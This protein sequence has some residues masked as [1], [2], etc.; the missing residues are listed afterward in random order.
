MSFSFYKQLNE[1]D[2]GPTCLRMVAKYYGRHYNADTIRQKTGFS[3]QGVSLLGI[4]ET[5][6]KLGFKTRG[7]Q[8]TYDKLLTIA[9]P[10][11]LH[12]NQNHF[13]V[14]VSMNKRKVQIADPARGMIQY[15]TKEFLP[16][17]LSNKK[18]GEEQAGTV[19]LLEPA[20]SFYEEEGEKENKLNWNIITR[21]LRPSKWSI[22][23]VFVAL[24]IGSL[25]QLILP[26]LSQ[27]M[28]DTGINTRNMQY[29]TI[30][31]VAQL[32]LTFSSTVIEFIRSRLQLRI[33]NT[34]NI[35]ILS[36]FWIKLTRLP[37]SYFDAHHTGDTIQRIGDNKQIQAFLT[38]QALTTIFSILNFFL[39]AVILIT[40]SVPLFMIFSVGST[41]YFLW[42]RLFMRI[43]RKI[44]Y[45]SFHISAKENNATLQ[46]V[47]GMQEIRLNNAE[48]LKRWEWE[49]IQAK[50]FKLTFR[51]LNYSQWQSAGALFINQGK[52]IIISFTVAGLV[53]QGQ[54]TFGA[55]IAIQYIIGQLSGPVHQFIGLSQ[56]IQD[57]KISM[58]R[59]NEVHNIEDEEPVNKT[60]I[61]ALPEKHEIKIN[62]L[63]FTYPSAGNDP[64]LEDINLTIPEGKVTAIV[65][66]SGSGK[67]TLIKLLLKVYEQYQGE[68]KIG[69]N[70]FKY[71]S[72]SFWRKQCGAVLQDGYI[73][74]D[75]I[76]RNIAVS[77]EYVDHDR[78]IRSCK[79]ANI[80]SF[81]E[82]LP[83]GFNTILGAEGVGVS[84]GQRQR[85][86]IARAVYKSPQYLFFDEAT[87]SLDANNEKTIVENLERFFH[88]RTVIVVAHRLSTVKNAHKI[89]VMDN[90]KI[91]EEGT[92]ASLTASRGKYYELVKNQLELGM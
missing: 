71:L 2:C 37:L 72:P 82:T 52:D 11:I 21:Y 86:L 49:N 65:G 18:N 39:Y 75:T 38:G 53:V 78:L 45:E 70:N 29:I 16:Y 22:A 48:Q 51:S 36:D 56:S 8:I 67:T 92:H 30:V 63:S 60:L 28:V 17:W 46:L 66:A 85:L 20:S 64:V 90:G 73:F 10:S 5:A 19:L 15:S 77:G 62:H 24:L 3:K 25:L 57:A 14:L 69:D 35:S 6:E 23:Q 47:Q 44:N 42:I 34:V 87:N 40:Y 88:G 79:I 80:F 54:L 68:I 12:W 76:A 61:A 81:I 33:S 59:L 50:I 4:S 83:N 9:H 7:V 27:S 1:M 58:E 89:I 43:R 74:N 55:M 31:L 32:T 41:V 84:Q 26:F 13:V 91:T